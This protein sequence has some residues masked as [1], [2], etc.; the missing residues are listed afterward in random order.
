M[1][2]KPPTSLRIILMNHDPCHEYTHRHTMKLHRLRIGRGTT[3]VITCRAS[4]CSVAQVKPGF[5]PT[6]LILNG[7][8]NTK[9]FR[10]DFAPSE[11]WWDDTMWTSPGP[12]SCI[13]KHCSPMGYVRASYTSY[14]Y[15]ANIWSYGILVDTLILLPT[16]SFNFKH[17]ATQKQ[18]EQIRILLK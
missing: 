9:R 7:W 2:T 18:I 15:R 5:R 13:Q 12:G 6:V 8:R 10:D 16:S 3:S 14:L 4:R 11:I 17:L 1:A